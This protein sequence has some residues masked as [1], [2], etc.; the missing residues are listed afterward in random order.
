MIRKGIYTFM[1]YLS[2]FTLGLYAYGS[3]HGVTVE[4]YRWFLTS[5][6]GIFFFVASKKN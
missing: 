2:A 3:T 5:M 4:P 1:S 6:F